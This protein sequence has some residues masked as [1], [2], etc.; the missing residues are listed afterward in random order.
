MTALPLTKANSYFVGG[1]LPQHL[2]IGISPRITQ[3]ISTSSEEIP[4]SSMG[5]ENPLQR[6]EANETSEEANETSEE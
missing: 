2:K 4:A 6:R 5:N 1:F 3:L